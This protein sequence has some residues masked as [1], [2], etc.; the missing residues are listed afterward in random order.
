MPAC[1]TAPQ[2]TAQPA[3][4]AVRSADKVRVLVLRL[5]PGDDL[6]PR[7]D[8]F[9]RE[10]LLPAAVILTAVGSLK[11]ATLRLAEDPGPT[12][13]DGPFEIVS[14]VGTLSPDG[15]HL[16]IALSDRTGRTIGGH[17]LDGCIIRTTA[18]IAIAVPDYL[19]F[20][21][22]LDPQT[23]YRELVIQPN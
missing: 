7:L 11:N 22:E 21:R 5:I 19:R 8:S 17:L 6:R 3:Q 23:G 10:N 16:H 13:F 20:S 18:E 14:L 4:R 2:G 12:H 15:P 1:T 9:T